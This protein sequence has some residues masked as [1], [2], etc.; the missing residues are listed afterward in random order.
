MRKPALDNS[1]VADSDVHAHAGVVN[2]PPHEQNPSHASLHHAIAQQ[3]APIDAYSSTLAGGLDAESAHGG[4][5]AG[6]SQAPVGASP[7]AAGAGNLQLDQREERVKKSVAYRH[8]DFYRLL[9]DNFGKEYE[10]RMCHYCNA[11]FSFKGGTT[12]AALRHLKTAHPERIM[13]ATA[14]G[15]TEPHLQQQQMH[16]PQAYG[17]EDAQVTA[18]AQQQHVASAQHDVVESVEE[19]AHQQAVHGGSSEY[20]GAND[21]YAGATSAVPENG[22]IGEDG[23]GEDGTMKEDT[24]GTSVLGQKQARGGGRGRYGT[25]KRKRDA[26]DA[27][28]SSGD[29][30]PAV[31]AT[32]S[33]SSLSPAPP[34]LT[35]SQLVITH[36]LQHHKE[37]L[38]VA[39]RLRFFKH[40]T[41]NP[42]EAEMY[43]VLDD[44]TRIEYIKEFSD[45]AATTI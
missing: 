15:M 35:A 40:V 32:S 39:S 27:G 31:S 22:D 41:H 10:R 44:A 20:D 25:A 14:A 3:S 23:D 29:T 17:E 19:P 6:A 42:S 38:S 8:T 34:S 4:M 30:K 36:F 45:D 1:N 37:L 9:V 16:A 24:D 11:V 7:G 26:S 2:A 28:K 12:S 43:N 21:Q 33:S 13:Y 18:D 5:L